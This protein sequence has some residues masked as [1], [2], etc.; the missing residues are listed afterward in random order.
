MLTLSVSP[1]WASGGHPT[2]PLP[3]PPPLRGPFP[4][5]RARYCRELHV[6]VEGSATEV[7]RVVDCYDDACL[8]DIIHVLRVCID[9]P[10]PRAPG[11]GGGLMG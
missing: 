11:R 4:Q 5:A 2:L 8:Y 3:P 10:P 7:V 6:H 1:V 9:G